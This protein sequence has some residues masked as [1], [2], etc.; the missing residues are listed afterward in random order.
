M[1]N[2]IKFM[3]KEEAK[4]ITQVYLET[5]T[6][7]Y[8]KILNFIANERS[9]QEDYQD[10]ISYIEENEIQKSKTEFSLFLTLISYLSQDHHRN[11]NFFK[12]I[13]QLILYSKQ[14]FTNDELTTIFSC[15]RPVKLILIKHKMYNKQ[16]VQQTETPNDLLNDFARKIVR[17]FGLDDDFFLHPAGHDYFDDLY[18][19]IVQDKNFNLEGEIGENSTT[20]CSMIRNDSIREFASFFKINDCLANYQ[21]NKSIFE[22]NR[23][24]IDKNL[25]LIE[26]A[27]FFGSI[28]II[29]Y[30]IWKKVTLSPSLWLFAVHSNNLNVIHLLED[31]DVKPVDD[32]YEKC[33]EEAIKCHHNGIALYILNNKLS[34]KSVDNLI[35]YSIRYGNFKL[36]TS[37]EIIDRIHFI[38]IKL[39]E[40]GYLNLIK[41]LVLSKVVI[42]SQA[43][44]TKQKSYFF[45]EI[46]N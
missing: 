44:I 6:K 41:F 34:Q 45:N 36:L 29:N 22:T 35:D 15:C 31:N 37:S 42:I 24:L 39:I 43:A 9:S 32:D 10:L 11:P 27:V 18:E 33:F 7:L 12:H 16:I 14:T 26:Y 19:E 46:P 13:E 2:L 30:L 28:K 1:S 20:V 3:D 38:F 25:T 8:D 23:F 17:S 4:R 40:N 5:A 21:I